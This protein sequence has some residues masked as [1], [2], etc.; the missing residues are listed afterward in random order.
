MSVNRLEAN[1]KTNLLNAMNSGKY[2]VNYSGHG[3]TAVWASSTFFGSDDV[4]TL[5]NQTNLSIY[6]M[7]TCLNGFFIRPVFDS[8]SE[9]LLKTTDGGA[10]AVWSSSGST[11]PDIQEIMATRFF[12]QIGNNPNMIR[13]GD[14][15]ND[16]K[17]NISGGSDVR[18]SWGLL[19]DPALR[20][21]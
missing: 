20:V 8:L 14:L 16:A 17:F 13:L 2:L 5:T 12:N 10:V 15:I 4:P 7:L 6:T 9:K 21:K 11:T 3:S 18:R 1:A 19:G